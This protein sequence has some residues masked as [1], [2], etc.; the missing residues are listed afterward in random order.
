MAGFLEVA[1]DEVVD[2]VGAEHSGGH[3]E[4]VLLGLAVVPHG[5]SFLWYKSVCC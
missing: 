5:A 4:L 1:Q 3:G 2:V